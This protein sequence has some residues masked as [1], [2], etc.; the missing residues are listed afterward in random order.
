MYL[1]VWVKRYNCVKEKNKIT[2]IRIRIIT[3]KYDNNNKTEEKW[4]TKKRHK[5]VIQPKWKRKYI[6]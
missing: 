2:K 6:H 3:I 4:G 1:S 5:H